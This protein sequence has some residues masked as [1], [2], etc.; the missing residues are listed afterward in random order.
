MM[1]EGICR[2]SKSSS[3]YVAH[4][5]RDIRL[6]GDYG[7]LKTHTLP[8]SYSAPNLHDFT[9]HL[10][11]TKMYTT[12]D[13]NRAYYHMPVA[14]QDIPK[15]AIITPFGLFELLYKTE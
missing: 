2:L 11:D 13:I 5:K 3:L 10:V 6:C 7:L 14:E 9:N 15:I 12:L 1:D 8:D 4:K